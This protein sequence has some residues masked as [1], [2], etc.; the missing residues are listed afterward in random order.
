MA[1]FSTWP[2]K[3]S[4]SPLPSVAKTGNTL[5]FIGVHA[6]SWSLWSEPRSVK[7]VCGA[8]HA[9]EPGRQF[10]NPYGLHVFH[11]R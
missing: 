3:R 6:L 2:R 4:A 7:S 9:R 10:S 5:C 11:H 8:L 1:G